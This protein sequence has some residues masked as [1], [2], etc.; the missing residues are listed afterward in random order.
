[1]KSILISLL[2]FFGPVLFM[3]VL[4]HIGMLLRIWLLW[5]RHKKEGENV[6]DITPPQPSPP[7]VK[8]IIFAFAAGLVI[9]GLVLHRLTSKDVHN[10]VYVPAH[11]N[12]QGELAPGD[13][14][15]DP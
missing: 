4:R 9:A 6:I 13:F 15:K 3:F 5:R 8:F 2:F 11:L 14:K 7:S 1:M 10:D 12:S